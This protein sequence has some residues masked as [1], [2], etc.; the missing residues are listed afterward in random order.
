MYISPG[1]IFEILQYSTFNSLENSAGFG[2]CVKRIY[3]SIN[4]MV[5]ILLMKS[6]WIESDLSSK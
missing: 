6:T 2:H 4:Q 3:L 1:L 5:L